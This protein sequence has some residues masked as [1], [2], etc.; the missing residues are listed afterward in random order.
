M[1]WKRH[2]KRWIKTVNKS[3]VWREEFLVSIWRQPAMDCDE[4]HQVDSSKILDWWQRW[5]GRPRLSDGSPAWR[6]WLKMSRC[7]SVRV[8]RQMVLLRQVEA[9]PYTHWFA[10]THNLY[11]MHWGIC[12]QWS[13]A[14]SGVMWSYRC[15]PQCFTTDERMKLPCVLQCHL[16][17]S[18]MAWPVTVGKTCVTGERLTVLILH[19]L[20]DCWGNW[21]HLSSSCNPDGEGVG[22]R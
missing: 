6:D 10:S 1:S 18:F 16:V 11:W 14:S 22:G 20:T 15:A 5:W 12:S 17:L 3:F 4:S 19:S 7:G 8:T 21:R 13:S 9:D 2:L